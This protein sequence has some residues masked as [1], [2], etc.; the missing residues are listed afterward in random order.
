MRE[1]GTTAGYGGTDMAIVEMDKHAVHTSRRRADKR[2]YALI[3]ALLYLPFL[4]ATIMS[5]LLAGRPEGPR[6]SVFAEARA[7][8]ASALPFA[9]R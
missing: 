8:A 4:A 6:R 9:F 7:A 3:F 1:F 2:E 5:R